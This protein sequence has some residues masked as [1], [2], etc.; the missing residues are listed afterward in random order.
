MVLRVDLE[1]APGDRAEVPRAAMCLEAVVEDPHMEES[2]ASARCSPL[3]ALLVTVIRQI[4][5]IFCCP[6]PPPGWV[7]W[8]PARRREPAL[9]DVGAAARLGSVFT[10]TGPGT[11]SSSAGGILMGL[12]IVRNARHRQ[13]PLCPSARWHPARQSCQQEALQHRKWQAELLLLRLPRE[14]P[15]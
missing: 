11:R 8:R 1:A 2:R 10:A 4:L 14:L 9:P 7:S 12:T 5:K 13:P 6:L 3:V 15:V